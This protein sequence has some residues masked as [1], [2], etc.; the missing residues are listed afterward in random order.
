MIAEA[1][2]DKKDFLIV[3]KEVSDKYQ[4]I[5]YNWDEDNK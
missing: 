4:D 3:I 1:Q 5:P 2:I